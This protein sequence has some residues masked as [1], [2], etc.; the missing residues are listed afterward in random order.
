[1]AQT[2]KVWIIQEEEFVFF[3]S[4][5]RQILYGGLG[6]LLELKV[7]T[8]DGL[9]L[10]HC[11]AFYF[12][13][14]AAFHYRL[15]DSGISIFTF[16]INQIQIQGPDDKKIFILSTSPPLTSSPLRNP[17]SNKRKGVSPSGDVTQLEAKKKGKKWIFLVVNSSRIL[18]LIHHVC[19]TPWLL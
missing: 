15:I 10:S 5:F 11:S 9:R 13:F 7:P 17:D 12:A 2:H 16:T 4:S 8:L 14:S 1:M 18:G 3:F 6:S 19:E